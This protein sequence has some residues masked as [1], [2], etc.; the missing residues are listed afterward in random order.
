MIVTSVLNFL[1]VCEI[2]L[3]VAA[4]ADKCL[5]QVRALSFMRIPAALYRRRRVWMRLQRRR[6]E[7]RFPIFFLPVFHEIPP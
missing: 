1:H 5:P 3:A 6:V 4:V 2:A 7:T